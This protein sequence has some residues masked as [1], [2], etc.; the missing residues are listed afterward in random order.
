MNGFK[1]LTRKSVLAGAIGTVVCT[2]ALAQAP[3]AQVNPLIREDR[4]QPRLTRHGPQPAIDRARELPLL[5]PQPRQERRRLIQYAPAL[6]HRPPQA[7][8]QPA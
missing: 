6:V 3:A 7:L 2:L 1:T 8:E 5:D 4:A